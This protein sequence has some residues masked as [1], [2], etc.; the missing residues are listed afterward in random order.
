MQEIEAIPW[1]IWW[2]RSRRGNWRKIDMGRMKWIWGGLMLE[3]KIVSCTL[4]CTVQY[5]LHVCTWWDGVP[6]C[7]CVM[8]G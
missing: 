3:W 6:A 1:G 5:I 2:W 8:V 4:L 7:C